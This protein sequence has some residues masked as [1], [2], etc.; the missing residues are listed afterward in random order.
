MNVKEFKCL[1]SPR[2]R[3]FKN[4]R[5][6]GKDDFS[7]LSLKDLASRYP[8]EATDISK[9]FN[10][11]KYQAAALR[12]V[13]RGLSVDQAVRKVEVDCE[14]SSNAIEARTEPEQDDHDRE[15]DIVWDPDG[16]DDDYCAQVEY[17]A[18]SRVEEIREFRVFDWM[19]PVEERRDYDG[20]VC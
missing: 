2:F 3:D 15:P 20:Y 19:T 18:E 8:I 11:E 6:G 16:N 9:R 17:E 10:A 12:W 5:V 14:I 13:G 7:R 4:L 1:P